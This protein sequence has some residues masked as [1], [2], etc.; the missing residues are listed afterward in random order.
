MHQLRKGYTLIEVMTATALIGLVLLAI[1]RI[2]PGMLKV[3]TKVE[4][5]TKATLLAEKKVEDI[6]SLIYSSNVSYGYAKNYTQAAT[7]FSSPNGLYKFTITDNAAAGIKEINVTVWADIDG[8]N[9]IDAD[10]YSVSLDTKV[11][12]RS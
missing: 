4:H 10:E 5:V 1:M 7:T 6:R 3:G 9:A 2:V 8:D 12:D 11:A